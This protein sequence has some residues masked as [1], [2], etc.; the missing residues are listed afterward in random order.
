MGAMPPPI[1]Q[2]V[3]VQ[4]IHS[5]FHEQSPE[6][7]FLLRMGPIGGQKNFLQKKH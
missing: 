4:H 3:S 2:T 6:K 1:F 5:V 7:N